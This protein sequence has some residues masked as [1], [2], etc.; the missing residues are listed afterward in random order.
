MDGR[1]VGPNHD[2]HN[3]VL[4]HLVRVDKQLIIQ[5][6]AFV[7]EPN[8]LRLLVS[9]KLG[10]VLLFDVGDGSLVLNF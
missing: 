8:L 5:L 6:F 10:A 1:S 7:E 2:R 9:C 4:G 3:S